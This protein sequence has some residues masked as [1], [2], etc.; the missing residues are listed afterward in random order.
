[1]GI[2]GK[3]E[4]LLELFEWVSPKCPPK[5]L[6]PYDTGTMHMAFEVTNIEGV[7]EKLKGQGVKFVSPPIRITE[8]PMKGWVWCYFED[9]DGVRLELREY[10]GS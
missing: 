4:D 10:Q 1:M 9:P 6:R 7:Y 3:G 5:V 2:Y 8:G